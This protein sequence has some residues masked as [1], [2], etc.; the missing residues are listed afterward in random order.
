MFIACAEKTP[1]RCLFSNTRFFISNTF[2]SNAK[3]KLA[4]NQAKPKQN[5]EADLLLFE[6]YAF[7][8]PTLLSKNN[9]KYSEKSTKN[10][11]VF[12]NEIM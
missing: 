2:I 5:S 8:S 7:S 9:R 11:H 3:L 6:N 1:P 4:K 10:K 12:L